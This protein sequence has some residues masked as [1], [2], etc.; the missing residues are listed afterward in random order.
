MSSPSK[1]STSRSQ[2]W[3]PSPTIPAPSTGSLA[4]LT[5]FIVTYTAL[6]PPASCRVVGRAALSRQHLR[7]CGNRPLVDRIEHE[8]RLVRPGCRERLEVSRKRGYV[9]RRRA[10]FG[11][12]L[13][14]AAV[15]ADEH[16]GAAA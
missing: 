16:A 7:D 11:R 13:A 1:P 2:S 8:D 15:N 10:L 6:L 14:R 3:R 4:V 9:D 5:R 12:S